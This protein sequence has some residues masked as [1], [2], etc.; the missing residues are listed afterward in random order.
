MH[1]KPILVLGTHNAKKGHE[2]AELAAPAGLDVRTLADFPQAQQ[3]VEDGDTFAAN[4]VLK[5]VQQARHLRQWVLAD[6]SGLMVD[7]LDGAPGVYSAR[8]AGP[9]AH[10][11]DNNRLLLQRLAE[12]PVQRR[13]A[14]FVCR[15]ALADPGGNVRAESE[16]LCRGRI[17]T[18][19]RGTSGFGY[20]PLFE[21]VEYHLSFAELGPVA[22]AV[23]SHRARAA[24]QLLPALMALV[25]A[26]QW[27]DAFTLAAPTRPASG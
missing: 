6:D 14:Q 3:V 18:A 7:A 12:L 10:D 17:L 5:A 16:G 4:A 9:A 24:G 21:I 23:L 15:M 2:L 13:A 20:D 25:D 22:K 11:A 27:T 1:S 26:G 8:F 19:P